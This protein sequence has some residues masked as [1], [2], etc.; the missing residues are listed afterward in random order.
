MYFF[1]WADIVEGFNSGLI[2]SNHF[3]QIKEWQINLLRNRPETI[4]LSTKA[5]PLSELKGRGLSG[6]FFLEKESVRCP[7]FCNN[8]K[9]ENYTRLQVNFNTPVRWINLE[10]LDQPNSPSLAGITEPWQYSLREEEIE[11][12]VA[13]DLLVAA[14]EKRYRLTDNQWERWEEVTDPKGKKSFQWV[15]REKP[16][17][18]Q[19]EFINTIIPTWTAVDWCG[20]RLTTCSELRAN[21]L[22]IDKKCST[23]NGKG[24]VY[25]KDPLYFRA[26]ITVL[27]EKKVE[28][29]LVT[30]NTKAD[31][32]EF[33]KKLRG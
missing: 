13:K 10:L 26:N 7:D 5:I 19:Q 9:S 33:L 27:H 17:M 15:Q 1:N 24:Y 31:Y 16:T 30:L 11:A 14:D 32:E 20:E 2:S 21:F 4:I 22:Q 25:T 28:T 3:C 23:C 6:F 8:G 18:P 29:Y 12:L